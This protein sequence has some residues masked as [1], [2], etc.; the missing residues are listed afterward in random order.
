MWN[1]GLALHRS[2]LQLNVAELIFTALHTQINH[3][4]KLVF[5]LVATYKL[6]LATVGFHCPKTRQIFKLFSVIV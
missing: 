1:A 6:S 2:K 4:P 3:H 5:L